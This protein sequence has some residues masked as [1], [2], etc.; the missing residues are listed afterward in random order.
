MQVPQLSSLNLHI[1][2][3]QHNS[4]HALTI[5]NINIKHV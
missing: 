2:N 4:T 5:S 1:R 3:Q